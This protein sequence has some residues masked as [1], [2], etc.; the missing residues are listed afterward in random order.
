MKKQTVRIECD[1]TA[2]GWKFS[3][4][5]SGEEIQAVHAVDFHARAGKS[6]ATLLVS[7]PVVDVTVEADLRQHPVAYDTERDVVVFEGRLYRGSFLR[8]LAEAAAIDYRR[9][10]DSEAS[11]VRAAMPANQPETTTTPAGDSK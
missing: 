11:A 10:M 1:G 7:T 4:A 8:N 9:I 3:H 6:E 5:E 2:L